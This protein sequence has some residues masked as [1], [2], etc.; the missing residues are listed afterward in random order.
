VT[1]RM[2]RRRAGRYPTVSGKAAVVLCGLPVDR[3]KTILETGRRTEFPFANN[4]PNNST[5]TNR[6]GENDEDCHGCTREAGATDMG[7]VCTCG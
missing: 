4:S 3:F 2:E 6:R 1:S 7:I 5:A